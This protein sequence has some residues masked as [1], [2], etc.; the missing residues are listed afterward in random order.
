MSGCSCTKLMQV[1]VKRGALCF[2][3]RLDIK[4]GCI[5]RLTKAPVSLPDPT[6]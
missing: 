1:L 3:N 2:Q 6:F 4:N 5:L